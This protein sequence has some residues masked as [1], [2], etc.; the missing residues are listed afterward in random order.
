MAK[1]AEAAEALKQVSTAMAGT[2]QSAKSVSSSVQQT[3]KDLFN[4]Y[5]VLKAGG[6]AALAKHA[7]EIAKQVG[8]ETT[9]LLENT[10]TSKLKLKILQN[11]FDILR[12]MRAENDFEVLSMALQ[13]KH[14]EKETRMLDFKSRLS[15]TINDAMAKQ[16][17]T[18]RVNGAVLLDLWSE[19]V[20]RTHEFNR[21]LIQA[22]SEHQTRF[23]LVNKILQVQRETGVNADSLTEAVKS[24]TEYGLE[25]GQNF[26][27]NLKTIVMMRDG[28][29]VSTETSSKLA[30]VWDR[31]IRQPVKAVAD[32]IAAIA[33]Q[34]GLAAG[35]AT[36]L[37]VQV[38]HAMRLLGTSGAGPGAA[39][40]VKVV[41]EITAQVQELGE[42]ADFVQGFYERLV[43]GGGMSQ[44]FRQ[45]AG[46]RVA[47]L[48][49]AEKVRQG[50]ENLATSFRSMIRAPERTDQYTQLL[51]GVA[52]GFQM[53]AYELTNFLEVMQKTH[54]VVS[55]SNDLE[56][57]YLQQQREAGEAWH[58]LRNAFGSLYRQALVPVLNILTP[59]IRN[60]AEFA[61][62]LV[63]S[64]TALTIAR[65]V[66]VVSA[67]GAAGSLIS[68][69][70]G[71][72]K[73]AKA[74]SLLGSVFN[75]FKTSAVPKGLTEIASFLSKQFTL[76][77]LMRGGL[78]AGLGAFLISY[79]PKMFPDYFDADGWTYLK[80][81]F[82]K[83]EKSTYA[84]Q[85][86]GAR[87]FDYWMTAAA[88]AL[89]GGDTKMAE[90]A[91]HRAIKTPDA[92][93]DEIQ[94]LIEAKVNIVG[95]DAI[96]AEQMKR[97]TGHKTD[98]EIEADREMADN[99]S[100][101][102]EFVHR[103]DYYKK[104]LEYDKRSNELEQQRQAAQKDGL[105]EL[106]DLYLSS[107]LL[108]SNIGSYLMGTSVPMR[109]IY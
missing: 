47:D 52:E 96:H 102:V 9:H 90:K 38:G 59:I 42:S 22:N 46:L 77:G 5:N 24:M 34:T 36:D 71:L 61:E 39:G 29:G 98:E 40:V 92:Q 30:A 44:K 28:L 53:S 18:A 41:A 19:T 33:Q 66:L 95:R 89:V 57:A 75:L 85:I 17:T 25:M 84:S 94:R 78:Y 35:R 60:M 81:Y 65:G 80:E 45:L 63:K 103:T 79:L 68:L 73:A 43:S 106:R 82:K 104:A 27:S 105:R 15:Y 93:P 11:E 20:V 91:I 100:K 48:D 70:N 101:L 12:G 31:G 51:H 69:S 88:K 6:I 86:T 21:A 76:G 109:A 4:A 49:N 2:A 32:T 16:S 13:I 83:Q 14:L 1:I 99:L 50:F 37:A 54:S 3:S 97:L 108:P 26:E 23:E 107:T 58:R 64:D 74:S 56:K 55:T 8:F 72:I 62:M 87:G 7:Y 67:L 10:A